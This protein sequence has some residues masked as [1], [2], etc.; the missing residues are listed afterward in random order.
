MNHITSTP[1]EVLHE[2]EVKPATEGTVIPCEARPTR[3]I[4]TKA[5]KTSTVEEHRR[6]LR[7]V[8]NLNA[9]FSLLPGKSCDFEFYSRRVSYRYSIADLC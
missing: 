3:T 9:Q 2:E 6:A 1:K 7:I 5:M 4:T 8:G